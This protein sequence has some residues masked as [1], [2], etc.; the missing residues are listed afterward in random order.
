[1]SDHEASRAALGSYLLGALDPAE[2]S[3]VEAHLAGCPACRDE[4]ASYAPLPGLMARL[5]AQEIRADRLTPPRALLPRTLAAVEA[6]RAASRVH[7]RRWRGLAVGVS[8][9]AAAGVAAVLVLP[10]AVPPA[11]GGAPRGARSL[12]AADGTAAA[13]TAAL[14][15]RA[16]G[17]QLHLTMRDLP[18]EGTF[19]AWAL[20]ASGT[21]TPAAT[22]QATRDGRA[23]VTGAAALPPAALS[24]LEIVGSNGTRVLATAG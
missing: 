10:V 2:R 19:T 4:L 7:L 18:R 17:T 23:E 6:E 12:V 21:R 13:G 9:L 22:W 1:M 24:G 3:T 5:S 20:D 16:W 15:S 11:P 14:E 8:A